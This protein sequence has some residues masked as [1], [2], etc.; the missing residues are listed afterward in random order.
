[1]ATAITDSTDATQHDPLALPAPAPPARPRLTLLGTAL[2]TAAVFMMFAG[3]LGVYLS[4]R[5]EAMRTAGTWLPTGATIPLTP[6]NTALFT[7]LLSGV[8]M[9]WAVYAVGNNDRQH[10]YLALALTIMFGVC[11]INMTSFLYSQMMLGVAKSPA[12]V[13]IHVITGAHLAMVVVAL[14]FAALMTFRTLG[15]EYAGRDREG[16]TAA[17]LFWYGTIAVY[18][19]VW[20]AIYVT[21]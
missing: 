1:M 11:F 20:F 16:I 10:A 6:G 5:S 12:G 21:K 17:A 2:A 15:G 14:V 8:T 19:V 18:F 7:L 4:Y 13:L 9:W 3:L